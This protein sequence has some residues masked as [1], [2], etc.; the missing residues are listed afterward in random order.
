MKSHKYMDHEGFC[1]SAILQNWIPTASFVQFIDTLVTIFNADPPLQLQQ[2]NSQY[3]SNDS[4][5]YSSSEINQPNYQIPVEPQILFDL[6]S[7]EPPPDYERAKSKLPHLEAK[8]KEAYGRFST[9]ANDSIDNL[10]KEG[11]NL[12][13]RSVR[14]DSALKT[15]QRDNVCFILL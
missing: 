5:N 4:S 1:T 12:Q 11:E 14:L 3:G 15:L 9:E 13:N 8:L 2:P 7:V 10:L 6:N